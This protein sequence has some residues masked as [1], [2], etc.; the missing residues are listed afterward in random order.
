[1]QRARSVIKGIAHTVLGHSRANSLNQRVLD[2]NSFLS[3]TGDTRG[4]RS[5]SR[6]RLLKDR[7]DGRRCF[8]I[9]NGPSLRGMDLAL[10][11]FET[12]FGLNRAYLMFEKLGFPTTFLVAVNQLV[13]EQSGQEILA[14]PVDE[15]FLAWSARKAIGGSSR[16]ILVRSLARPGFST[17]ASRGVWE[18]A[19]VTFVAMQLAYYFGFRDVVLIG[20]DHSFASAGRPHQV[21]TSNG[22][23][24]N[25]F[26]PGYFGPGYRWQLP[27]LETSEV[28]YR[29]AMRAFEAVGGTIRDATVG[30]KLEVFPKVE[31]HS[32]FVD[33]RRTH[34][35]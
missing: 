12:T 32:L 17:D 22:P 28:A 10:L 27:D 3:Y 16:P 7:Y 33:A 4:R 18:G 26:D 8:I 13:I 21:V 11:R 6:L 2:A 5:A 30:G 19:T 23:D 1:M 9:G 31:F 14:A 20:V 34:G 24:A 29:M 25:H 35:G 15:V